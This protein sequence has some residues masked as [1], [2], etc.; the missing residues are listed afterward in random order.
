MVGFSGF[1]C[2]VSC[3]ACCRRFYEGPKAG[4]RHTQDGARQHGRQ[5]RIDREPVD[6]RLR[7][8][9]QTKEGRPRWHRAVL[10]NERTINDQIFSEPVP[11]IP[12]R[13]PRVVKVHML[14]RGTITC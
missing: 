5:T 12:E 9:A 14:A 7:M 3:R 8:R 1:G 2:A 13:V 10:R 6:W 4:F 11:R